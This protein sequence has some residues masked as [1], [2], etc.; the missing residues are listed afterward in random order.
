MQVG[1]P[2]LT[3]RKRVGQQPARAPLCSGLARRPLK[4]V[5]RVRIPS[6][7]PAGPRSPSTAD[8]D[9]VRSRA[10]PASGV[11]TLTQ[12]GTSGGAAGSRRRRPGDRSRP[13]RPP[14]RVVRRDGTAVGCR[15]GERDAQPAA[16]AGPCRARPC[17]CGCGA[18]GAG[19][20]AQALLVGL[21]GAAQHLGELVGAGDH[22]GGVHAAPAG[23]RGAR[24]GRRWRRR[25]RPAPTGR[26]PARRPRPRRAR[27]R[28]RSGP[29]RGG[30]PRTGW[31]R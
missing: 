4:A 3:T 24:S 20:P 10:L 5:A 9:L 15:P 6:G 2:P 11:T 30:G 12:G 18:G 1:F 25:R 8:G 21:L 17:G 16:H 26:G 29:S 14:G 7:L 31:W 22:G 23:A 27:A 19:P 13:R 28:R